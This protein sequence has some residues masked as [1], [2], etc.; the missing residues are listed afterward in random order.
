MEEERRLMYV[1]LTRTK[2]KTYLLTPEKNESE[3]IKEI[4]KN[5]KKEIK[6][7]KSKAKQTHF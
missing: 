7:V 3:F 1:A 2:N 6:I 4:K 5:H